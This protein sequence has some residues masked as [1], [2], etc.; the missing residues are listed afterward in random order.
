MKWRAQVEQMRTITSSPK[1]LLTHTKFWYVNNFLQ[2]H[3]WSGRVWAWHGMENDESVRWR[4]SI[5]KDVVIG[6]CVVKK[7]QSWISV[8]WLSTWLP[9]THTSN[10][11]LCQLLSAVSISLAFFARLT[12][13]LSTVWELL[14]FFFG[15]NY[16]PASKKKKTEN[17]WQKR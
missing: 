16:R 11:W 10:R 1:E 12:D 3:C 14:P 7:R 8:L 2:F 17:R 15:R 5:R 6:F 9:H 4:P 13:T